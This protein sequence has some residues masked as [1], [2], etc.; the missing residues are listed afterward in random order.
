MYHDVSRRMIIFGVIRGSYVK[1]NVFRRCVSSPMPPT[2]HFID[3]DN[4]YTIAQSTRTCVSSADTTIEGIRRMSE[5]TSLSVEK[6]KTVLYAT[7]GT[8]NYA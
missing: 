2:A 7:G 6:Y 8:W 5:N 4:A 3:L 1:Q